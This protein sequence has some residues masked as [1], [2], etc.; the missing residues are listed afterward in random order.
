MSNNVYLV[1]KKGANKANS[2]EA[3]T[4]NWAE[5]EKLLKEL[6]EGA[7]HKVIVPQPQRGRN[8]R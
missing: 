8:K 7:E 5:A 4:N 1:G 6:G 3:M 2:Y